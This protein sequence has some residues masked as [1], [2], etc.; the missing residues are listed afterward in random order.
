MI[1]HKDDS[2]TF[3]ADEADKLHLVLDLLLNGKLQQA[4]SPATWA[5]AV[6]FR[7]MLAS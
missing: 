1:H 3:T 2:V 4:K 5:K 6:E 7:D